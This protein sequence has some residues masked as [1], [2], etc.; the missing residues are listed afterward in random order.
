[1]PALFV[2]RRKN[3]VARDQRDVAVI[4]GSVFSGLGPG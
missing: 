1:L 4:V 3:V 2:E